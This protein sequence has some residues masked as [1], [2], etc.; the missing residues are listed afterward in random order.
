[1]RHST[2]L[3]R[4]LLVMLLVAIAGCE[5]WCAFFRQDTFDDRSAVIEDLRILTMQMSEP[6]IRLPKEVFSGE[7]LNEN[8]VN[9]EARVFIANPNDEN[10]RLRFSLCVE[11]AGLNEIESLYSDAQVDFDEEEDFAP[12]FAS[13]NTNLRARLAQCF[14]L[15]D[16]ISDL[17]LGLK[18]KFENF[19]NE[20]TFDVKASDYDDSLPFSATISLS[21]A[22]VHELY[23][24]VLSS[25]EG[26]WDL[27]FVSHLNAFDLVFVAEI[28]SD[29]TPQ[30][31]ESA[32]A[33]AHIAP[34]WQNE[35]ALSQLDWLERT[36]ESLGEEA[37]PN[38]EQECSIEP[39]NS[40]DDDWPS[41][42]SNPASSGVRFWAGNELDYY[43]QDVINLAYYEEYPT[44]PLEELEVIQDNTI[45]EYARPTALVGFDNI[46]SATRIP[47]V[48]LDGD[49]SSQS[50]TGRIQSVDMVSGGLYAYFLKSDTLRLYTIDPFSESGLR[51]YSNVGFS[52]GSNIALIAP[53][54][55]DDLF[56][57]DDL[58]EEDAYLFTVVSNQHGGIQIFR[59]PIQ[60]NGF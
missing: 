11:A 9:L 20:N 36:L 55:L 53:R 32:F 5:P 39:D 25:G 24:S 52:Y 23:L 35:D 57:V 49:S 3:N 44:P 10:F 27:I 15:T 56:S 60:V 26:L 33:S 58:A 40:D 37:Y 12:G 34:D 51:P 6:E 46:E 45:L 48:S 29:D 38:D 8:P 30:W 54:D 50:C 1:M 42:V 16:L 43:L 59:N 13:G 7:D 14:R 21:Q 17:S 41:K 18:A 2:K 22:E 47:L 19:E 4:T 28:V 31:K